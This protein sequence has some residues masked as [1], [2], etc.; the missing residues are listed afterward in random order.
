M[1]NNMTQQEKEDFEQ[2]RKDGQKGL[3]GRLVADLP[4]NH[5]NNEPY[6]AGR[7]SKPSPKREE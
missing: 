1:T 5:P 2:G 3:L 4:G 6:Y 7:N